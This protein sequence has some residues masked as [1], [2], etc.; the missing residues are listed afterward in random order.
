[1]CK[2]R[3]G[4]QNRHKSPFKNPSFPRWDAPN[5]SVARLRAQDPFN[6]AWID[7][8]R[9]KLFTDQRPFQLPAFF[10]AFLPGSIY[11]VFKVPI[12]HKAALIAEAFIG[13]EI[14]DLGE[15]ETVLEMRFT[16]NR[17][18]VFQGGQVL[19]EFCFAFCIST[20][21]RSPEGD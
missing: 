6:K 9:Q 13:A 20:M 14:R 16:Q 5:A 2:T 3:P 12:D 4:C 1:M 11:H 15:V 17:G 21:N 8:A 19:Q 18:H 10:S 7:P